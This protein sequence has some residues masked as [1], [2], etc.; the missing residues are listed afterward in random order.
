MWFLEGQ[1][2]Q[3][4]FDSWKNTWSWARKV[5]GE[6]GGT[7]IEGEGMGNGYTCI[8]FSNNKSDGLILLKFQPQIQ[9]PL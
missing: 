1:E 9:F 7:E 5:S 8:K 6:A 3:R 2:L 4:H